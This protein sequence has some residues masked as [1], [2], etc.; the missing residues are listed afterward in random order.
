MHQNPY[1]PPSADVE[2]FPSP[3]GSPIKAIVLGLLVDIGGTMVVASALAFAYAFFLARQG[4][5]K[6]EIA[7]V[8]ENQSLGTWYG[9]FNMLIG[10]GFSFLGGLVCARTVRRSE[11]RF[12]ALLASLLTLLGLVFAGSR[13]PLLEL[14]GTSAL[15]IV[16][17]M[18]GAT[19]GRAK[20]RF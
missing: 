7:S 16:A 18:A 8:M 14:L 9:A 1:T 17:V 11:L 10:V 2:D 20:D 19:Y 4:L 5:G 6:Q 15:T 13:L 12:G 3:P